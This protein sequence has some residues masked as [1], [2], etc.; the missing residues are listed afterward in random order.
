MGRI[1]SRRSARWAALVMTLAAFVGGALPVAANHGTGTGSSFLFL[2]P[3]FTQDVFGVSD[4]FMGGVA[5]AP[6]GD[7][8]VD[9]CAF[10]GDHLHRYDA[11]STPP[12][13]NGTPLHSETI[14][15]SR[16]GCGLTNHS[17]GDMYTNTT[18]GVVRLNASTGAQTGGPFGPPGNALGIAE[19]PETGLVVYVGS[20]GTL[21][22]VNP[23]LSTSGTFSTVTTGSF[24]D[25]IAFDPTGDFLMVANRSPTFRLTILNGDTGAFIQHV[26]MASEP[27]GI[28]FHASAP[29]FVVTNNTNGTMTRFDFPGDDYSQVPAQSVFASGGFRGDLSQV[30]SDGCIYLTQAGTRYNNQVVTAQHSLV[31]ICGGFAPAIP[32]P[33][34]L[35]LTPA[36]DTNT[37]DDQH[38]VTATVRDQ[39]GN[40]MA[41]ITV[42]FS[43]S[44]TTF[45]TPPSGS[46]ET[47]AA[48]EATFC[49]TSALPGSDVITAYADTNGDGSNAPPPD[50]PED[51]ANKT[52]VIPAS[53][54]GCKVTNG[55][56]IVA[57]NGDRANFGGNAKG[58]GPSGQQEYQ[59][60]GP[61]QPMNVHSIN[62]MAVRCS[63]DGTRASIF[64]K[65]TINGAGSFDYR[66]D[67]TDPATGSDTYR[68]RLSNGYDSGIRALSGGNVQIH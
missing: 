41:G 61:A 48:G 22:T 25:G 33:T 13:V 26:P 27:D 10:S 5:F 66:I 45:R 28:S 51:T 53:T 21:R 18:S 35:E 36:T 4:H 59:D 31:Q 40:P 7:P 2:Q 62:V 67:V 58:T 54:A 3:D 63:T 9:D 49:Y 60:H 1:F 17:G 56:W 52:W 37:V 68:L 50:E 42:N 8:W 23:S 34:T 55:G 39:A 46:D 14:V 38:C 65:A 24:V 57:A 30:G 44:P 43:V 6:D 29:K 20:D 47:D 32:T 12:P 64:G 19:D 16:A 11:Q 15:A